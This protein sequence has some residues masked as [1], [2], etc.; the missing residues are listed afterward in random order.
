[1]WNK[2]TSSLF[3]PDWI[4]E[5]SFLIHRELAAHNKAAAVWHSIHS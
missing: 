3:T 1:M 5:S 4:N 2:A